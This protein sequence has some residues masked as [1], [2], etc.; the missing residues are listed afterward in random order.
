MQVDKLAT[1]PKS[2]FRPPVMENFAKEMVKAIKT[3]ED[4]PN[5]YDP[6]KDRTFQKRKVTFDR[7]EDKGEHIKTFKKDAARPPNYYRVSKE[8]TEFES[9]WAPFYAKC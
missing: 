1:P 2:P 8:M 3:I 6:S 4:V 7:A 9:K 5:D